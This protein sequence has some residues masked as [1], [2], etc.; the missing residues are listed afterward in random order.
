MQRNALCTSACHRSCA[1]VLERDHSTFSQAFLT[2]LS[3]LAPVAKLT[4]HV[5][6]V[7]LQL[8][9]LACL[10]RTR[11]SALDIRS[12]F[13]KRLSSHFHSPPLR[14]RGCSKVA[15]PPSCT[16]TLTWCCIVAPIFKLFLNCGLHSCCGDA[17]NTG[18]CQ[19]VFYLRYLVLCVE[20]AF[21]RADE[22]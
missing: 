4:L 11:F 7:P 19:R 18:V 21:P 5:E 20:I 3:R 14:R 10:S 15:C 8:S 12:H 13:A 16:S 2:S 17:T 6:A 9:S 1:Y 22:N